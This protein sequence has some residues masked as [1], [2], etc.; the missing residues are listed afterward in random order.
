VGVT[1][2]GAKRITTTGSHFIPYPFAL[3]LF[4]SETRAR[5]FTL[6]PALIIHPYFRG[7][8][9]VWISDMSGGVSTSLFTITTHNPKRKA[10]ITIV[11]KAAR[12]L[13]IAQCEN[14]TLI[15][16]VAKTLIRATYEI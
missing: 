9:A 3:I 10:A 8:S 6:F 2:G 16:T 14:P 12:K 7:A 15:L 5:L 1:G 4:G 11:I 13:K